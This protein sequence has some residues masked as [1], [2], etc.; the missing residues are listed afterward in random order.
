MSNK[1]WVRIIMVDEIKSD[2][3]TAFQAANLIISGL[4]DYCSFELH[5]LSGYAPVAGSAIHD[6][7]SSSIKGSFNTLF[8][9]LVSDAQSI[10]AT[11]DAFNNLDASFARSLLGIGSDKN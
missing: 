5:S 4:G 11:G 1:G 2:A 9:L 8:S 10:E 6:G 3:S 7:M